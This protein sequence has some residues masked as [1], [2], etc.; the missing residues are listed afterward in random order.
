[1]GDYQ[2]GSYKFSDYLTTIHEYTQENENKNPICY[3]FPITSLD[4]TEYKDLIK[5]GYDNNILVVNL[6]WMIMDKKRNKNGE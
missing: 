5:W 6:L 3:Y 1:M 2:T 4:L